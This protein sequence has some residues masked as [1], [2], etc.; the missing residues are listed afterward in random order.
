MTVQDLALDRL[1]E[2]ARLLA[3]LADQAGGL[4]DMTAARLAVEADR[5]RATLQK[6]TPRE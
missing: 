4:A 2:L 5:M 6:M 3:R 1:A